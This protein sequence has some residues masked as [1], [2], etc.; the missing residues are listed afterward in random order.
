MLLIILKFND[1]NDFSTQ[2]NFRLSQIDSICRRQNKSYSEIEIDVVKIKNSG[3]KS[4]NAGHQQLLHFPH[5]FQN[6]QSAGS[7]KLGIVW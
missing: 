4:E 6:P 1:P 7:L 2:Q 3:G 5:C